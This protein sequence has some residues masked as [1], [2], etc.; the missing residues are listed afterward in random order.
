ML[1]R[2]KLEK[3][4]SGYKETAQEFLSVARF[5]AFVKKD[6]HASEDTVRSNLVQGYDL[7]KHGLGFRALRIL[8]ELESRSFSPAILELFQ[9]WC[10]HFC[11]G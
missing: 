4:R 5:L 11:V 10:V 8:D 7:C 9:F 6:P 3:P 1:C 2:V